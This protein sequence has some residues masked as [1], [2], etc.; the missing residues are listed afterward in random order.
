MRVLLTGATGFLGSH[1]LARLRAAD[2][3][4]AVLLRPGSDAWR[5]QEL[6]PGVVQIHGDL[7]NLR[8]IEDKVKEFAPT[9]IIH[10]AW[11]G[12]SNRLRNDPTQFDR[13]L[14]CV[15]ALVQLARRVGCQTW[16]GLGSQAEY[17]PCDHPITEDTPTCPTSLYGTAKLCAGLIARDLC[18]QYG[19]RFVW[20]RLFSAYGPKDDPGWLIPSVILKLLRGE[21]PPLTE[22]IQKWDYLHA[23]DVAEAVYVAAARDIRVVFNLG[24]G[25]AVT[26]RSIAERIRDLI[27]PS[28]PLGVGQ[29][30]YR[31]DQVMHLQTDITRFQSA[32]GWLPRV[33][34]D[35]G[36]KETVSWFR[37][38]R[39]RYE[40]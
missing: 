25:Q 32:T 1:V 11:H 10:L 26:V 3:P 29:V 12:V 14:P 6:L 15:S 34:L 2:T 36:L 23:T 28:L 13:N 33:S 31:A 35:D 20:L 17:G 39:H 5:V 19:I 40:R 4:V 22:G 8:P 24:S 27:D 18:A 30:P 37:E 16:I 21:C 9:T 7:G 38:N